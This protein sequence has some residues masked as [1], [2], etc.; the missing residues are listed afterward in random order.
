M[1][2]RVFTLLVLLSVLAGGALGYYAW[3]PLPLP[4]RPYAFDLKQGSSLKGIA[5]ILRE[6]GVVTAER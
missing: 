1:I 2:R 4:A 3:R 6:A 5:R